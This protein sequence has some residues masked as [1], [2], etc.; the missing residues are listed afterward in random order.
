MANAFA[1]RDLTGVPINVS[2]D[3]ACSYSINIVDRFSKHLPQQEEDIRRTRFSIDSLHVNNHLDKCTYFF[4]AC[5]QLCSAHFH[6][7]GTEQYWSVNNQMGPQSCQMNPGH[8]H[9]KII[10]H[11]SFWNWK[12]L[13]R[14]GAYRYLVIYLYWVNKLFSYSIGHRNL[15]CV[16]SICRKAWLLL[17]TLGISQGTHPHLVSSSQRT[18]ISKWQDHEKRILS[19]N[20]GKRWSGHYISIAYILH[21]SL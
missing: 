15:H 21:W 8:R 16:V 7:V 20:L 6:G 4:G 9:D 18:G 5:Y 19:F 1:S 2:Y 3:S 10:E 17:S 11:H 12:K 13:T 14:I